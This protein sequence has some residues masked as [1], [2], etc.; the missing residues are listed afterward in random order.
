MRKSLCVK[1][2]SFTKDGLKIGK[3]DKVYRDF[4]KG[5][6]QGKEVKKELKQKRR[7]KNEKQKKS[8]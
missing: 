8:H 6:K 4:C 2:Q 5:C 7:I 1:Y 3:D